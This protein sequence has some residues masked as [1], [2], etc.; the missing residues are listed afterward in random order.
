MRPK[1]LLGSA[2]C[3][4]MLG[5]RSRRSGRRAQTK[6]G[7][8]IGEFLRIEPGA[9][10][11]SMGNA[12]VG[13][14]EGIEAVYFSAGAIGVLERPSLMVTHSP[15]FADITYDYAAG[16]FPVHRWGTFFASVTSLNS[17]EIDVRTVDHP[18]GT[19]ERYD[20]SDVAIGVG[21]GRPVTSRFLAG[22]QATFA[23]ERI[24][25]SSQTFTTFA[26]G[27]CTA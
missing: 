1:N 6:A 15:W 2:A 16:S 9:R 4:L 27:R 7:T 12:G 17:G 18:L 13:M 5:W 25:H 21:F 10:C 19:G 22:V 20:V 11:A 8:T 24:W 14:F 23:R 3:F 26:M